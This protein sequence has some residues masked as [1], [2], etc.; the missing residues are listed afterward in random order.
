MTTEFI[1]GIKISDSEA[2]KKAKISAADVCTKLV[3]AFAEQI[4][5]T[6]FIHADPHPG[7]RKLGTISPFCSS[8]I[9]LKFAFPLLDSLGSSEFEWKSSSGPTRSRTVRRTDSSS[10]HL[11]VLVMEIDCDERSHRNE[12]IRCRTRCQW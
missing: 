6:G 8:P 7:N 12:E 10:S 11:V 3:L 4:F 2:L 9:S 5:H 1:D